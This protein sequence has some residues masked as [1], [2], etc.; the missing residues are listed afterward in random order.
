MA[1]SRLQVN[2]Y[3][4]GYLA[5]LDAYNALVLDASRATG[6]D[7]MT[8]MADVSIAEQAKIAPHEADPW[9]RAN[10][11]L[12]SR[13]QADGFVFGDLNFVNKIEPTMFDVWMSVLQRVPGSVMSL[14]P[15]DS[16]KP[17]Y[18]DIRRNLRAEAAARGIHPSRIHF[19]ARYAAASSHQLRVA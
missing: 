16:G 10:L 14:Q 2:H 4:E 8:T 17:V 1:Q 19:A 9:D 18:S 12:P 7:I 11:G 3:A 13:S 15:G 6:Q 5:R